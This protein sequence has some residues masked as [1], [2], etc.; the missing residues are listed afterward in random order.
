M[1]AA[2]AVGYI[3]GIAAATVS[4]ALTHQTSTEGVAASVAVMDMQE[5][6]TAEVQLTGTFP[7]I[8]KLGALQRIM[9]GPTG[10]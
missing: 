3:K 7:V 5:T 8:G 9:R 2:Q 6:S 4:E 10:D 1:A